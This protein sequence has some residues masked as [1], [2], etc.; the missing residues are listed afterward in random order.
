MSVSARAFDVNPRVRVMPSA[1]EELLSAAQVA[2]VLGVSKALVYDLRRAGWLKGM[3]LGGLK[4]RRS[5]VNEFIIA[6]DGMDFTD[7]YNPVPLDE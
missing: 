4:W 3:K 6:A 5:T 2:E 7:P 1:R